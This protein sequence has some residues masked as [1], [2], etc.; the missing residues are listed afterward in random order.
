LGRYTQKKDVP[1]MTEQP[2]AVAPANLI[3]ALL[4]LFSPLPAEASAA[5]QIMWHEGRARLLTDVA[6]FVDTP[7]AH[8]AAAGAWRECRGLIRYNAAGTELAR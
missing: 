4:A 3:E 6:A 8:A 1:V 5:E 7:E 2:S